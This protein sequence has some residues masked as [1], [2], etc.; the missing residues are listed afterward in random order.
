[1][2]ENVGPLLL[3]LHFKVLQ[4]LQKRKACVEP[5][6]TII[7]EKIQLIS[8]ALLITPLNNLKE[9]YEYSVQM[10]L[11]II[12]NGSALF[13][14]SNP[15]PINQ[16]EPHLSHSFSVGRLCAKEV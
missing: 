3:S 2:Y 15:L 14:W 12:W 9:N 4:E 10:K 13:N 5:G 11:E 16:G 8:D 7:T 6:D 1:M